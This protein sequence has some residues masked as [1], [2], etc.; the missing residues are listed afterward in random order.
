MGCFFFFLFVGGCFVLV[1]FW[2]PEIG[3]WLWSLLFCFVYF[4]FV[5]F[6]MSYFFIIHKYTVTV[7]RQF[8]LL[9]PCLLT[10]AVFRHPR[11]GHQISLQVVVSYHVVTGDLNS[12][13]LEGQSMLLPTE[14]SH[15][16]PPFFFLTQIFLTTDTKG[17]LP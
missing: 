3:F 4:P 16:H 9:R 10:V 7:F 17:K 8:F 13:P 5:F 1:W 2:F 6:L 11:R 12:G 14:P 15:Q